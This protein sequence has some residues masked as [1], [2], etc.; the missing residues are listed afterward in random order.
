MS[1]A[2]GDDFRN[3]VLHSV[4]DAVVAEKDLSDVHAADLPDNAAGKWEF[5]KMGNGLEYCVF[6]FPCRR[7]VAAFLRDVLNAL[8]AAQFPALGPADHRP[9]FLLIR[10]RSA[11]AARIS[12]S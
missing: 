10:A 2:D 6:P 8:R 7:P 1:V 5:L 3:V 4:D 12:S 11:C 9:S